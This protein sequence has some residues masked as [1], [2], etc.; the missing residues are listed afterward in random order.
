MSNTSTILP[1][2]HEVTKEMVAGIKGLEE[3]EPKVPKY[4]IKL[5]HPDTMGRYFHPAFYCGGTYRGGYWHSARGYNYFHD[6]VEYYKEISSVEACLDEYKMIGCSGFVPCWYK[7]TCKSET[8][9]NCNCC[10]CDG[11][12]RFGGKLV[13]NLKTKGYVLVNP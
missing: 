7:V 3:L 13:W 10:W 12:Y 2:P 6:E 5:N 1:P 11:R 4:I 8:K 9:A